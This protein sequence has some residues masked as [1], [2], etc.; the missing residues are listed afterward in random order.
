MKTSVIIFI[1]LV[2]VAAGFGV[3]TFSRNSDQDDSMMQKDV[4]QSSSSPEVMIQKTEAMMDN[5]IDSTGSGE[6]MMK[7]DGKMMGAE[8]E[9]ERYIEYSKTAFE[10]SSTN[11][12]VLFFYASWCPT[13]RPADADFKT[14]LNK[15]PT[16]MTVLRVNYNDPDTDQAEKDLAKQYGITYQHTFVQIDSTGKQITKWN[17]GKTAELVANIK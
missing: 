1:I 5:K 8:T 16:D 7:N 14:N 2:I 12:R 3:Y 10:R 13:C 11:R 4:S 6:N 15:I 17:G 9:A